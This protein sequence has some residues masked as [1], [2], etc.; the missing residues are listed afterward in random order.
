[1]RAI[2]DPYPPV[3][4][5]DNPVDNFTVKAGAVYI[6]GVALNNNPLM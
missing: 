6:I 4:P 3:C 1:M 2:G 5:V